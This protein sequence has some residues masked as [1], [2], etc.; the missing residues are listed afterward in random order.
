MRDGLDVIIDRDKVLMV[1]MR[2][3]SMYGDNGLYYGILG[4]GGL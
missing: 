3:L 4:V 2:G 1:F